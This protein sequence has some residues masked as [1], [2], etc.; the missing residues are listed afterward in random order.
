MK[1]W[2]LP[3]YKSETPSSQMRVHR[4][5]ACLKT[6]SQIVPYNLSIQDK[7]KLLD[8][9]KSEDFV[10][11]QK[12]RNEFNRAEYV[13]NLKGTK[14]FDIDDI[15]GDQEALDLADACDIIFAANHHLVEWAK[16]K[17]QK[18]VHLIPT[19]VD[20]PENLPPYSRH[21]R[22]NVVIAKYGVDRY[23]PH[24]ARL[25]G[26]SALHQKHHIAMRILGTVNE[27][28]KKNAH[29]LIGE[30]CKT[31]P[32]V[33]LSQFWSKYGK[34]ISTA[35][36]GIMPL[37]K[38]AQGKSA[39]SVLTMMAAGTP[40]IASPY[41]ECDHIIEHGVN[42]FLADKP[43]DWSHF[44][45]KLITDHDTR[46]QMSVEAIKTIVRNYTVE[47]IARKIELSIGLS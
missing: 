26:W 9:V 29:D 1:I 16:Q 40:V 36:C 20:I 19:A 25:P 47:K 32:L 44:C 34:V 23:I 38:S 21:N 37:G 46:D 2:L 28:S 45:E 33:P 31:Y 15:T 24:I 4:I 5:A 6:E 10:L 35:T 8:G 18:P 7:I 17:Y 13:K 41:G 43:T 27:D 12:W 30:F 3:S 11:V 22:P 42:G 14:I 39:F